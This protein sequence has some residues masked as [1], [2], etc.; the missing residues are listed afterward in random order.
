MVSDLNALWRSNEKDLGGLTPIITFLVMS[1]LSHLRNTS[2]LPLSELATP[3]AYLAK[4]F[5]LVEN[6][7]IIMFLYLK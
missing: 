7:L 5:N 2:S 4:E 1:D 3:S 6:S